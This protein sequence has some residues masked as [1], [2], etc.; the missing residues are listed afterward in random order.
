MSDFKYVD[1]KE[2]LPSAGRS[3][4]APPGRAV[5]L[6]DQSLPGPRGGSF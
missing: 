3:E 4:E 2:V 5:S 1:G 6:D